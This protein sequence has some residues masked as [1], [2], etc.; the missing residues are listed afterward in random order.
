VRLDARV[1]QHLVPDLAE[2]DVYVC[3][4]GAFSN[5]IVT[6]AHRLGVPG[7]QIHHEAFAF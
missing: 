5:A 4:P 7:N 6:A 2:R 3:G 1:L